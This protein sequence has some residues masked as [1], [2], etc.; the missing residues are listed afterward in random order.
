MHLRTSSKIQHIINGI[1]QNV[2]IGI[3]FTNCIKISI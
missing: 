3:N 1:C 2:L